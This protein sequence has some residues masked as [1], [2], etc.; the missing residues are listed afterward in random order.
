MAAIPSFNTPNASVG[1]TCQ[2]YV[3]THIEDAASGRYRWAVV[4]APVSSGGD[5]FFSVAPRSDSI[6]SVAPSAAEVTAANGGTLPT[7]ANGM[8]ADVPLQDGRVE[9]W[10]RTG[11]SWVRQRIT[12][13]VQPH[14]DVQYSVLPLT[15]AATINWDLSLGLFARVTLGGNRTL[16]LPTNLVAGQTMILNIIQDA[17]GGRTLTWNAAFRFAGGTAPT[18]TTA[19]N[20]RDVM[21]LSSHDGTTISVSAML[22]VR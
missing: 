7:L 15:D 19:A 10:L 9:R 22:D 20:A 12:S 16:A 14:R 21:Y 1:D 13:R 5:A 18:L 3:I 6:E 2:G 8:D 4:V 11:G 17:T